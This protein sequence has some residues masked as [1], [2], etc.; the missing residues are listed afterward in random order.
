MVWTWQIFKLNRVDCLQG[1]FSHNLK[2]SPSDWKHLLILPA[3]KWNK[4][5]TKAEHIVILVRLSLSQCN[6]RRVAGHA[7]RGQ[8]GSAGVLLVERTVRCL[9][10]CGPTC[11]R[12]NEP[13]RAPD[14]LHARH[15]AFWEIINLLPLFSCSSSSVSASVSGRKTLCEV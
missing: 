2:N 7:P 9:P 13:V 12:L 3:K 11:V 14:G 15:G 10:F 8:A 6:F 4:S 5:A 1:I